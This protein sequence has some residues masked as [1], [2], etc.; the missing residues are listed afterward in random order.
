MLSVVQLFQDI[1]IIESFQLNV[2]LGPSNCR[3]QKNK[4]EV[5]C[6]LLG[7]SHVDGALAINQEYCVTSLA[8]LNRNVIDN[9]SS[10]LKSTLMSFARL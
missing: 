8:T 2:M 3:N 6:W 9:F 7:V 4:N 5:G 10:M 1:V